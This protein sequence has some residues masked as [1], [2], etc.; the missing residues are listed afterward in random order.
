MFKYFINATWEGGT[1]A[2]R[3]TV[4]SIG[5]GI[6]NVFGLQKVQAGELVLFQGQ[7]N[8]RVLRGMA[9]NLEKNLVGVVVFGNDQEVRQGDLVMRTRSIIGV[10]VG[11]FVLGRV[12]D[13]LGISI[14]STSR[15]VLSHKKASN[16]GVG[17]EI[18]VRFIKYYVKNW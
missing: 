16:L 17:G 1:V 10:P 3:G 4:L 2:N 5:D 13:G 14:L 18:F 12:L 8:S 15:G 9:L 6:A 7:E 11:P